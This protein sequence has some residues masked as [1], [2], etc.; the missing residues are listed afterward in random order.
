M[1]PDASGVGCDGQ[2]ASMCKVLMKMLMTMITMMT[3]FRPDYNEHNDDK[4]RYK[5][6]RH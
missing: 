3:M 5:L 4:M 1:H 2:L 6:L